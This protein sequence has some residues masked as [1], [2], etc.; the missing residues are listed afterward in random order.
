MSNLF[1]VTI[2]F[3]PI[4]KKVVPWFG[5]TILNLPSH[6]M[7]ATPNGSGDTTFNY[8]SILVY[9]LVAMAISLL[10][11]LV[12]R[13]RKD[14]NYLL[15]LFR[16]LLRYYLIFIMV[17]YGLSKVFYL[18]FQPPRLARLVQN[19]GDSS[20]MGILW[21]FMGQSK[22]YTI[23][24]GLC[25]I[26]GGFFLIFR[27]TTTLGALIVFGV[28]SN[29]VA[30]NF[31]YDVPVKLFSSHLV[32]LALILIILDLK[33]LIRFFILN[34][35]AEVIS[36]RPYTDNKHI[37][38]VLR[39]IK[40]LII[41]VSSGYFTYSTYASVNEYGAG[42]PKPLHYGIYEVESFVRN[43]DTIPPLLTN[44]FRWRRLI[45]ERSDFAL[46]YPMTDNV[47]NVLWYEFKPDS[48][49][50]IIRINEYG[51]SR[52][53]DSLYYSIPNPSAFKLDGVLQGDTLSI[54]FQKKTEEDFLLRN[55]PF[56]WV[57]EY[58]FNK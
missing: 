47:D 27:R 17:N 20:P 3:D 52:A 51:D 57:N 9:V 28:M 22:G 2:V 15:L 33:R 43:G 42:A 12:D 23:F 38:K 46:V 14:Y 7:D 13:K 37:H 54:L 41:I 26:V 36:Y 4:W 19:Y 25:E 1:I 44:E 31:F 30:L 32:F 48:L 53:I 6:M 45:V 18:Q 58:P 21:T 55:R 56:N 49:S 29:V 40:W 34:E 39:F 11:S 24:A 10:W 35:T 50:S 5:N 8:V 16:T